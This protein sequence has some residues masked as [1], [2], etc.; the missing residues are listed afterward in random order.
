MKPHLLP[1]LATTLALAAC[2]GPGTDAPASVD[3]DAAAPVHGLEPLP[4]GPWTQLA[5]DLVAAQDLSTATRVTREVLARGGMA[6]TDGERIIVAAIGPATPYPITALEA[7]NLAIEARNRETAYRLHASEFANFLGAFGWDL[8]GSGADDPAWLTEEEA[9]A[10]YDEALARVQAAGDAVLA[11]G[12]AEDQVLQARIPALEAAAA[13]A[14]S[15]FRDAKAAVN[16]VPLAQRKPLYADLNAARQASSDA[17]KAL[18]EARRALADAGRNRTRRA[19][20][21]RDDAHREF[22]A[23]NQIGP[24]Y[25]AGKTLLRLLDTW[26][27]EAARHPDDPQSFTPL[28]L[29]EMARLQAAPFDLLGSR[30]VRPGRGADLPVDLR[31]GPR[32]DDYR[33]TLLEMQLFLAAFQRGQPPAPTAARATPVP[34]RIATGIADFLLPPA[35]ATSLSACDDLKRIMGGDSPGEASAVGWALNESGNTAYQALGKMYGISEAALSRLSQASKLV[36][37]V[38]QYANTEA[39][40][41]AEQGMVHKPSGGGDGHGTRFAWFTASAGVDPEDLADY[42]DTFAGEEARAG[43]IINR[44]FGS[45]EL[46]SLQS[47]KEIADA[48][49][50]WRVQWEIR[51]LFPAHMDIP[52]RDP[53][54]AFINTASARREM[55]LQRA[56]P[57]HAEARLKAGV[58]PEQAVRGDTAVAHHTV[59]AKVVDTGA[60]GAGELVNAIK[61]IF[62]MGMS[63]V[64]VDLAAGWMKHILVPRATALQAIEYHCLD[65]EFIR[66][67]TDPRG[68]GPPRPRT[69]DHCV[70]PAPAQ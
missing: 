58:A 41:R 31:G 64:V 18:R 17:S 26:V 16:T 15:D 3:I 61:G 32:S 51:P 13:R 39:R 44:C 28:F 40:V 9:R 66:K 65:Q 11:A 70:L 69:R 29:A 52:M 25:D 20:R 50:N 49:E 62:G 14:L 27:R 42:D 54:N 6:T 7:R 63:D 35:H 23:W 48:A 38:V 68:D 4:E 57:A 45:L 2:T 53:D 10:R 24:D 43:E 12:E 8:G 67:V 19:N 56:S 1:L 60:P 59:V 37:V 22:L 36:R 47:M 55:Q 33:M 21:A 46:P 34:S 30:Y 5:R